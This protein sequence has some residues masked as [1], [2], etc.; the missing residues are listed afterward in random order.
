MFGALAVAET[1]VPE[2][3]EA[4]IGGTLTIA[5]SQNFVDLDP[6]ISNSMYDSYV[7][8]GIYD[9]LIA[10]D[11]DTLK[12]IP[13]IAKSWEILSDS[14]VRFFL[15]EGIKFHNGEDLTA[16]DVA[17]TFN[18]MANPE[19]NSPNFTEL[20]WLQ[21]CV[22]VDEYTVDMIT[23]PEKTP[24]APG[25]TTE[26]QFIVP[27][28]TVL[29]M[30]DEAF[31]LNPV[32]SGPYKF[33]EWKAAEYIK[34]ERNEDYWLVYPNLDEVIYRPIP[35]LATMMLELEAGGVDIVDNMPAQDVPRFQALEHTTVQQLAGLSYFYV[36]FNMSHAPS[37]DI[38]YRKAVYLSFD[39][40]AA[41]FSI[42][43]GLTAIRA[44][45]CIPPKLW[46]SDV[47]YLRDNVALEEDDAE[48]KRLFAELKA[49]GVLSEGYTTTIWCPT[50]PRRVQ[51]ATIIATNLKENG[52][53]AIVQPTSWGPYLDM[54]YRSDEDPTAVDLDQGI[55][56]WSG[57]PDPTDFISY[58]FH[59]KNAV[60]GSADNLSFYMNPEVDKL[61]DEADTN[62]DQAVREEKYA[63]AQ[64]I[65]FADYVNIPCYHL[66]ETIGLTTRVKGYIIDPLGN[67]FLC[68]P[69]H[70]VW[71]ED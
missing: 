20:D 10:L 67:I 48:A 51:L 65:C 55:L 53:N 49:E 30:G 11:K 19:N 36:F 58:M 63:A 14:Q 40:E 59:S 64:R 61:I 18:W 56:G 66:I 35:E 45:G 9:R 42:F 26:T 28:D 38:R 25:F 52:L 1:A 23:K 50:D 21:E 68:D 69:Q 29:E 47:E 6:R 8:T 13:F 4:K 31:N 5:S 46:A 70:N 54:V 24:W 7:L 22:I 2:T 15:N 44:Y 57:G 27:K 71:V 12:P 3:P 39:A 33:V 17:F 34:L 60:P 16:E 62:L 37:S 43:Q 32:G 41:V